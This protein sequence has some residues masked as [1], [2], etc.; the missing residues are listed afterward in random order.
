[1]T[2]RPLIQRFTG[3]R[4]APLGMHNTGDLKQPMVLGVEGAVAP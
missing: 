2:S 1:M 3:L 4:L